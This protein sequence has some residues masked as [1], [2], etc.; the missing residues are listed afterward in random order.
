M[1]DFFIRKA[2]VTI[3]NGQSGTG[4]STISKKYVGLRT[5]FEI[6]KTSESHANPIKISIYN[7][8][9]DSRN[10]LD[11]NSGLR[12]K[13]EAGYAGIG[14]GDPIMSQI[15]IGDI[16]FART[17]REGPD[18]VTTI[19][20]KDAGAALNETTVDASFSGPTTASQVI[21]QVAGK[22]GLGVGTIVPA[23]K[24]VFQ[25]GF[26]FSGKAKDVMDH[27]VGAAG[28]EWHVTDEQINVLD[29]ATASPEPPILLNA[30]TGLV[31]YPSKVKDKTGAEYI[32]FTALIG[33][34]YKPGRAVFL[35]TRDYSQIVRIRKIKYRGDTHGTD[36]FITVEA[37]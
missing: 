16:D 28:L 13:L 36:W 26:S 19:E 21:G 8:N 4:L 22:F 35:E 11:K 29:P 14:G 32:E 10:A 37:T 24:G 9:Q 5:H 31:G 30:Q 18:L 27:A 6:D 1:T 25:N 20:A 12:V 23:V 34:D 7:L 3:L 33:P 17:K 15:C 2:A